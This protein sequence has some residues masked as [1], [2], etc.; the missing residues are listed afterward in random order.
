VPPGSV[1]IPT[2][3]VATANIGG[4]V[5]AGKHIMV[6]IVLRERES[7]QEAVRRLRKIIERYLRATQ[8]TVG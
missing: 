1:V 8:A 6:K 7:V 4:M 3:M 5:V 2:I